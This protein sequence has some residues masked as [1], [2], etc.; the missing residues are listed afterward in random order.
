MQHILKGAKT[1]HRR[2]RLPEYLRADQ[3]SL[4]F[5]KMPVGDSE[6][7]MAYELMY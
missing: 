1:P 3:V 4:L 7:R 6:Y 5:Q 2:V